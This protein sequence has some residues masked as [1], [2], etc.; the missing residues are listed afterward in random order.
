MEENNIICRRYI[1]ESSDN[2]H[3]ARKLAPK[4]HMIQYDFLALSFVSTTQLLPLEP[5]RIIGTF[6]RH[7]SAG[8]GTVVSNC[9]SSSRFL[10]NESVH[11]C[12]DVTMDTLVAQNSRPLYGDECHSEDDRD[13]LSITTSPLSLK[14][15][16]PPVAQV[17][18]A[19]IRA[20]H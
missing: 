14:F 17:R 3:A 4:S 6:H 20:H 9:Q 16:L 7:S 13:S 18:L 15:A 11:Y 5:A 1:S 12:F 2:S 10:G 19:R 8:G